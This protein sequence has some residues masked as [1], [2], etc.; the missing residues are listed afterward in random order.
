MPPNQGMAD[1]LDDAK[2]AFKRR[3]GQVKGKY[4]A[5]VPK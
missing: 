5:Q 4:R 3:Y 2:A 1:T